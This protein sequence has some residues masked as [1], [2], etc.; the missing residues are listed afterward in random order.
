M[1]P[2]ARLP[3]RLPRLD[4]RR[5]PRRWKQHDES[6]LS[7]VLSEWRRLCVSTIEQG[8]RRRRQSID[9]AIVEARCPEVPIWMAARAVSASDD[10]AGR[11]IRTSAGGSSFSIGSGQRRRLGRFAPDM[12]LADFEI[13]FRSTLINRL[14][15]AVTPI[16]NF[17][18]NSPRRALRGST[19]CAA[20]CGLGR[21]L[22]RHV[23]VVSGSRVLNHGGFALPTSCPKAV[24][25]RRSVSRRRP[26]IGQFRAAFGHALPAAARGAVRRS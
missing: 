2:A 16:P 12:L 7:T 20:G 18:K 13:R 8:W 4:P 23:V 17:K 10:R 3:V 15:M 6:S 5:N 14:N 24:D 21:R 25:R 1:R 11:S 19:I 9:N 26:I 22:A